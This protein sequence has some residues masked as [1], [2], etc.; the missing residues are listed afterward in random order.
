MYNFRQISSYLSCWH[1]SVLMR[2]NSVHQAGIGSDS[3]R[4]AS[5]FKLRKHNSLRSIHN[6]TDAMR[7]RAFHAAGLMRWHSPC[8]Q[9]TNSQWRGIQI[10]AT[11]TASTPNG[12]T[13]NIPDSSSAVPSPGTVDVRCLV[14]CILIVCRCSV[15]G[16]GRTIITPVRIG[17]GFS[18]PLYAQR[19]S[20]RLQR[21][22]RECMSLVRVCWTEG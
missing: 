16:P 18:N 2:V 22:A 15:R 12:G 17:V 13:I 3:G 8:W 6:T 11:P 21:K 20:G 14:S 5:S 1:A 19:D 10:N 7:N 9:A 4:M